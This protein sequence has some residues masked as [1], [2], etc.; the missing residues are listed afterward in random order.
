MGGAASAAGCQD[1]QRLV[2]EVTQRCGLFH[3]GVRL[4]VLVDR[5]AK[6]ACG[7]AV[8]AYLVPGFA[9]NLGAV[10]STSTIPATSSGSGTDG[11]SP[12]STLTDTALCSATGPGAERRIPKPKQAG[13]LMLPM[14]EALGRSL[15]LSVLLRLWS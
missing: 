15:V 1:D 9:A 5:A 13:G 2:R 12:S 6:I 11:A 7:R 14:P 10:E 8:R 4:D 3:R